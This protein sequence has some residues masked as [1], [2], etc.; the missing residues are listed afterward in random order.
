[1]LQTLGKFTPEQWPTLSEQDA[2]VHVL[3]EAYRQSFAD[4]FEHVG[5]PSFVEIPVERLLSSVHLS[6]QRRRIHLGET[7]HSRPRAVE[8]HG[9]S[10]I[11]VIDREGN[12]VALT[13]T[14]NNAFGSKVIAPGSGLILND[15]LDDFSDGPNR[16]RAHARPVSSM[17][18]TLVFEGER[19]RYVLGGS[20]G[21][22]ISTNVTTTL[23]RLLVDGLS[24][25]AAVEAPRFTIDLRKNALVL[26]PGFDAG[27]IDGLRRRGEP[28][29]DA[30]RGWSAVQVVG[31]D[32]AECQTAADSRKH[33][34]AMTE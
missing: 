21:M 6:E 19:I 34:A 16:P 32:A 1:L 22:T 26:E 4:R 18:P 14:V 28:V 13:T 17:T 7:R 25:K 24:P 5:D 23:L 20:G 12:A 30:P 3:A 10:H 9:T 31:C 8:E 2:R 33:G 15:E 29:S 27:V 11:S